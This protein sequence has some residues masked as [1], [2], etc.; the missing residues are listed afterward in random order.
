MPFRKNGVSARSL[1]EFA[2]VLSRIARRTF[3]VAELPTDESLKRFWQN[4]RSIEQRWTRL[5]SDAKAAKSLDIVLLESLAPRLFATEMI[6]RIWSTIVAGLGRR[7][8]RE[9]TA[10]ITLNV[11]H[12]LD[13]VRNQVLSGL[14]TLPEIDGSRAAEIDR[15]RRRTERWTDVLLGPVAV[16]CDCFDFAYDADRARDFGEEHRIVD[17]PTGPNIAEHLVCAGLR[18][19]FLRYLP[20]DCHDEPELVILAQS[21]LSNVPAT[22]FHQ[23]GP[24]QSQLEQR[25]IASRNRPESLPAKVES[26]ADRLAREL[27]STMLQMGLSKR[28]LED[29]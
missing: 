2:L 26:D 9:D 28:K 12:G 23:N 25:I 4:G 10:R 24:L 15:L 13:R 8:C 14:L 29:W 19:T 21:I 3:H 16:E 27:K 5:L 1:A 17:P 20:G 11:V 7:F 18:S 22:S 6:A